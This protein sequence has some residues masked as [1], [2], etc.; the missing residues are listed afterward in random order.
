MDED[1]LNDQPNEEIEEVV[2][3]PIEEQQEVENEE[4]ADEIESEEADSQE[5]EEQA[6]ERPPSRRESL[7]IQKLIEKLKTQQPSTPQQE[8]QGL[9]YG[10]ALDADPAVVAQLEADRK[11]YAEQS[12]QQ[13]L[14]QAQSI[15]FHTRLEIDAP[16]VV[17]KY[18]QLNPEDK[19]HFNPALAD[20]VNTWYL[21]TT[22]YNPDTG[23]VANSNVRYSEFVDSIFELG[24]EIAGQK[25]QATAK[26]IARQAATTGLRPDGSSSKR[27]NLN[28]PVENMTDEELDAYGK[29]LGLATVKHR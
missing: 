1:K 5:I 25:V 10:E 19:E 23:S 14:Q 3:Q 15:Q 13:G 9:N 24:N 21:T 28:Q 16:K 4:Q 8:H 18:S 20:A 11:A 17:A 27:L 22:G 26:N 2:D 7:R 6:E 12:Y 29:Q